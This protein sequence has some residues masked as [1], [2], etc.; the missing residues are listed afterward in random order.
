MPT[1]GGRPVASVP[2]MLINVPGP[3]DPPAIPPGFPLTPPPDPLEPEPGDPPTPVPPGGDPPAE[4]APIRVGR[5]GQTLP[6]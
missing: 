4:P 3:D 1:R 2:A 6:A 5:P